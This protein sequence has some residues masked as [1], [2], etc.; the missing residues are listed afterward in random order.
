MK[1][2]LNLVFQT[3]A[4]I[5]QLGN[6]VSG[7]VP[8]KYQ[9]AVALVVALAQGAVAWRSHYFNPD[10]SPASVSYQKPKE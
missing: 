1:I 8:A 4:S 2:T 9:P 10:G 5:V 6:Q 3:L 7:L